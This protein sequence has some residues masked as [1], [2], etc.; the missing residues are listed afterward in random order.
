MQDSLER[1][2]EGQLQQQQADLGTL[3]DSVGFKLRLPCSSSC[4]V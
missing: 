2:F 4:A 1:A 3:W